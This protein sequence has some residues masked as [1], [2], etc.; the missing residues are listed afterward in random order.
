MGARRVSQSSVGVPVAP[1][2]LSGRPMSSGVGTV[3]ERT[4]RG[5]IAPLS[6]G[7]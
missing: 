6:G 7:R 5:K 2:V 4:P 1:A 3:G